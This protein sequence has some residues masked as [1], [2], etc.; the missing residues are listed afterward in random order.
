MAAANMPAIAF[1]NLRIG[2]SSR[3]RFPVSVV[4]SA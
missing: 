3:V 4:W 1:L 2:E